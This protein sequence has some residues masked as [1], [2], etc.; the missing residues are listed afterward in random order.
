M[1]AFSAACGIGGYYQILPDP[2]PVFNKEGGIDV[3]YITG[4]G[5][6]RHSAVTECEVQFLRKFGLPKLS[7]PNSMPGGKL[8]KRLVEIFTSKFIV[9]MADNGD[10]CI[11]PTEDA[12]EE[13]GVE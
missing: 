7:K 2:V 3:T 5:P 1:F 8:N 13:I 10:T 11:I 4:G 9:F 12:L 6:E